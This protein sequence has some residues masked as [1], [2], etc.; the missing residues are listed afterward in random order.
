VALLVGDAVYAPRF[1]APLDGAAVGEACGGEQLLVRIGL[2]VVS[3]RIVRAR[4]RA[5]TCPALVAY[6]EAA[7]AAL[8][9]GA[10]PARLDGAALRAAVAGAHPV[11]HDR[12]ELVA[13]AVQAARAR[14]KGVAA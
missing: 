9:G 6:A 14:A 1:T 10:D 3:G 7:C 8:E 4:W 12:A 11:H 2:W 5:T 13:A